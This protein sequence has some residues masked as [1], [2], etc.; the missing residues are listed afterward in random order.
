MVVRLQVCNR[1]GAGSKPSHSLPKTSHSH[2]N[3]TTASQ[4]HLTAFPNHPTT[5]QKHP[6]AFPNHPTVPQ[7]Q[8]SQ[9]VMPR[10]APVQLLWGPSMNQQSLVLGPEGLRLLRTPKDSPKISDSIQESLSSIK[11][12][13]TTFQCGELGWEH[14]ESEGAPWRVR[15]QEGAP[16]KMGRTAR[17]NQG[18]LRS[19]REQE[20]TPRR[21]RD[22]KEQPRR[23]R[24]GGHG[25]LGPQ[26]F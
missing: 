5:S 10:A 19:S 20:R 9:P 8:C 23:T 3:H 25:G 24:A 15:E 26:V 6:T 7:D 13:E 18:S 2:P 21:A 1:R 17:E 11:E 14:T 4:K 12:V 22:Q 16:R